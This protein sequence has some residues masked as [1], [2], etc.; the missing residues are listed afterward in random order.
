MEFTPSFAQAGAKDDE[1]WSIVAFVKKLPGLKDADYK[2]WTAPAGAPAQDAGVEPAPVDADV[3]PGEGGELWRTDG[4]VTAW[5]V[6]PPLAG[7]LCLGLG[8]GAAGC[9]LGLTLEIFVGAAI[10]L[11][12]LAREDWRGP[13][14]ATRRRTITVEDSVRAE[15]EAAVA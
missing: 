6:T 5:V 8:W 14:L 11:R 4:V 9:W 15:V 3:A 2:S 7:A 12:R 13:A 10:L 1:I